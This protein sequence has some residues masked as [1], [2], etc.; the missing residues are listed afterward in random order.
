MR[1]WF[2]RSNGSSEEKQFPRWSGSAQEIVDNLLKTLLA[3]AEEIHLLPDKGEEEDW[4]LEIHRLSHATAWGS[5][6]QEIERAALALDKIE[7]I[8]GLV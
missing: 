4:T 3:G 8:R 6:P 7:G 1:I 2:K 5:P